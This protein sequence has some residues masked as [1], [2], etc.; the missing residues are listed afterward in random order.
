MDLASVLFL[1]FWMS[2]S[3]R[4]GPPLFEGCMCLVTEYVDGRALG[5]RFGKTRSPFLMG[6]GTYTRDGKELRTPLHSTLTEEKKK[7]TRP[8]SR[9][10]SRCRPRFHRGSTAEMY[11]T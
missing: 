1:L 6:L 7:K 11:N 8:R 9:L 4:L 10:D 3:D 5:N 2:T